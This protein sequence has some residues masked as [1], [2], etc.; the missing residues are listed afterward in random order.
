MASDMS[1]L[2][3]TFSSKTHTPS[4]QDGYILMWGQIFISVWLM[5]FIELDE[6]RYANNYLWRK[7]KVVYDLKICNRDPPSSYP[8]A[9]GAGGRMATLFD[10]FCI[11]FGWGMNLLAG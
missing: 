10:F 8:S 5:S 6:T 7:R 1:N 3:K 2:I 11:K 9:L 4:S